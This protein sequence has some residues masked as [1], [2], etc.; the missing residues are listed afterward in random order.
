MSVKSL[1]RMQEINALG[2]DQAPANWQL[3]HARNW[4]D[5]EAGGSV[6]IGSVQTVRELLLKY[7][8]EFKVGHI[9]AL[10]QFGSL[11]DRL[12]RKNMELLAT[13][14]F[15]YVRKHAEAEF[16][17]FPTSAPQAEARI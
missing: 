5:I 16:S 9:L 6:L 7:V 14:V 17:S 1:Q 3:G 13:E 2:G 4:T 15:P 11:P 10:P 12:T 8:V